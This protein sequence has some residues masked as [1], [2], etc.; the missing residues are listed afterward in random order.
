MKFGQK[1]GQKTKQQGRK[2]TRKSGEPFCI[3]VVLKPNFPLLAL[4]PNA[5]FSQ[6]L[7]PNTK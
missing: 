4:L 3:T 6:N 5:L 7:F 2:A 1:R